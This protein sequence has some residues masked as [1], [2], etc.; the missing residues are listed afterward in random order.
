MS[1]GLVT[2]ST[3]EKKALFVK[4][5]KASAGNMAQACKKAK[6]A[7]STA[8]GWINSDYELKELILEVK[9]SLIDTAESMLMKN[10]NNGKEASI[11]FFLKTQAQHRGY[12]E[13]QQVE[14]KGDTVNSVEVKFVKANDDLQLPLS[15]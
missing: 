1:V 12:I 7:R 9:E 13:K 5:Y 2:M 11:F 10:I 14:H 4:A 8:Y 15:N 6:I 3:E